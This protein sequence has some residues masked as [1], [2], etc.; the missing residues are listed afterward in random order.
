MSG[1]NQITRLR[2]SKALAWFAMVCLVF[3]W[4]HIG[5]HAVGGAGLDHEH[6]AAHD[7]HDHDDDAHDRSH[8]ASKPHSGDDHS[9]PRRNQALSGDECFL[10]DHPPTTLCHAPSGRDLPRL[11]LALHP[12]PHEARSTLYLIGT[13]IR[14]PPFV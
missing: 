1:S 12:R 9:A 10:A 2:R 14:G 13:P 8:V 4:G 3:G 11:A 5:L 6:F 7:H